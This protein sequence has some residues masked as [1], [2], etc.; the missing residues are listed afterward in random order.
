[1][2]NFTAIG[3]STIFDVCLNTYGDLNNLAKLMRDSN[4]AGVVTYPTAGQ[5]FVFDETKVNA[6]TGQNLKQ[7][8]SYIGG[9]SQL[10]YAT[11]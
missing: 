10:K 4:H 3:G 1:M 6:L 11:K 7:T 2:T 9:T 8:Y 5:V